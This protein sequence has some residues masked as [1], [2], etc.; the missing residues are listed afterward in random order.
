MAYIRKDLRDVSSMF[1]YGATEEDDDKREQ[2]QLRN[3]A[4]VKEIS[5]RLLAELDRM[6][7]PTISS[8]ADVIGT[9][10][11]TMTF[12]FGNTRRGYNEFASNK[13]H[14][15]LLKLLAEFGN[16]VVP[17][18]WTY[19]AI[20][21]NHG[22]K[23]KKHIDIHNN[24]RSVIIGIG[25]YTGGKVRVW[26]TDGKNPIEYDIHF[27]PTMFNGARMYHETTPFKGDR[28]SMIFYKQAQR[29]HSKGVVM[30][31]SGEDYQEHAP[32]MA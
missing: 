5:E 8:R 16:A 11:R 30:K 29:G 2:L 31:G 10:G 26:D 15:A 1:G 7:V 27:K 20:T 12:G 24:G 32:I 25:D 18:G 17:K 23:A 19:E 21:L 9:I 4:K 6:T 28:Y 3:P 14:P 13:Q 22:V